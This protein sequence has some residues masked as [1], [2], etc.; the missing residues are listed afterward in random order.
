MQWKGDFNA[1]WF[2]W[3]WVIWSTWHSAYLPFCQNAIFVNMP[4]C[5][6]AILST[7][8]F[9]ILPFCQLAILSTCDFVNLWFCQ[10]ALLSTCHSVNLP[11]C[12]LAILSACLFLNLNFS[13][14]VFV[15]CC[16][17]GTYLAFC[18]SRKKENCMKRL[19]ANFRSSLILMIYKCT[20]Y[21]NYLQTF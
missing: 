5:Q 7:C 2:F 8:H 9:D 14:L 19:L 12:Q 13:Q 21:Y 17:N 3:C 1:S 4:S 16:E 6:L 20:K 10:L 11:F 18:V 15:K